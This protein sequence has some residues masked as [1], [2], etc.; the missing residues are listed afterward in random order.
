[1]LRLA[2]PFPL[3]AT[4]AFHKYPRGIYSPRSDRPPWANVAPGN[5]LVRGPAGGH[6]A[7]ENNAAQRE[8][9]TAP[10]SR[11]LP[12]LI[13]FAAAPFTVKLPPSLSISCACLPI[14]A[15]TLLR[16][17]SVTPSL[18]STSARSR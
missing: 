5:W 1:M 2:D 6:L 13:Y 17:S 4:V 7:T 18:T 11:G 16:F 3:R 14:E 15:T 10:K 9:R 12:G 8:V